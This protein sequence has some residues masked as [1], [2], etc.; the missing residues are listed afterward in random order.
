M[1]CPGNGITGACFQAPLVT[2]GC[3]P[4]EAQPVCCGAYDVT[5]LDQWIE[6]VVPRLTFLPGQ[7]SS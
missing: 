6:V 5:D 2:P 3:K 7:Q 1:S 4:M